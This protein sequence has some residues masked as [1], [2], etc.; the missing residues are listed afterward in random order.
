[1]L[2]L[3]SVLLLDDTSRDEALEVALDADDGLVLLLLRVEGLALSLRAWR[4]VIV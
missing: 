1:V 3:E 2:R 4:L